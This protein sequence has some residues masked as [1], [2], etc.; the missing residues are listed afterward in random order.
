MLNTRVE[1]VGAPLTIVGK[2][3]DVGATFNADVTPGQGKLRAGTLMKYD[4]ATMQLAKG[5][6]GDN[7]FGVLADEYDDT[8][9][10]G[11]I[12][13]AMVY[14]EGVFLRQEIESANNFAI[15][16]GGADD[17]ALR[18]KGIYLEQS[19]ETYVGLNPVPAG[20]EPM[21]SDAAP[22]PPAPPAPPA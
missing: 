10:G 12:I 11:E 22:A 15:P 9:V 14:R 13:P 20:V 3:L 8:N 19:Y 16:P 4:N 5:A 21:G 1:N 17:L 2:D 6:S 18:D 7:L